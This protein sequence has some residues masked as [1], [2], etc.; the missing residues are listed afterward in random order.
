M[1]YICMT[2]FTTSFGGRQ[3][4]WQSIYMNKDNL[5]KNTTL[6][7]SITNTTLTVTQFP[8]LRTD[9]LCSV[10]KHNSTD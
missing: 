10:S 4:Q 9:S 5:G 2:S 3:W 6:S 7:N 1:I 8:P